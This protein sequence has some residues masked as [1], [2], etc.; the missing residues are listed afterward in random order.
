MGF[1]GLHNFQA[2]ALALDFLDN[3]SSNL[4]II[5]DPLA[6]ANDLPI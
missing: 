3:N 1:K 6:I 4:K 2:V 5:S